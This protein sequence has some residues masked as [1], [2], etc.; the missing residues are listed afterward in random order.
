VPAS[1]Y[2]L[3]ADAAPPAR[4]ALT[5]VTKRVAPRDRTRGWRKRRG[6]TVRKLNVTSEV[7][8]FGDIGTAGRLCRPSARGVNEDSLKPP[9]ANHRPTIPSARSPRGW[10]APNQSGY[11]DGRQI[12]VSGRGP[13]PVAFES[14]SDKTGHENGQHGGTEW[15]LS[16]RP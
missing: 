13:V 7:A 3:H 14:P 16:W 11:D 1:P 12:A 5:F 6:S 2:S 15:L 4:L 10:T 9:G 8:F